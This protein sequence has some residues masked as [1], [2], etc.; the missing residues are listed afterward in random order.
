MSCAA[1]DV[2]SLRLKA[3]TA[4]QAKAESFERV[5]DRVSQLH[6]SLQKVGA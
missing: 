3:A 1:L 6:A 2:V 5:R 4:D